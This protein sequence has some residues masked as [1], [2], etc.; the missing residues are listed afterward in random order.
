M[1]T[2]INNHLHQR[3]FLSFWTPVPT[4]SRI[5]VACC[6]RISN[7]IPTT[8]RELV[9]SSFW[10]PELHGRWEYSHETCNHIIAPLPVHHTKYILTPLP[11][12]HSPSEAK[13]STNLHTLAALQCPAT[14]TASLGMQLY[15][16]RYQEIP[17]AS[18]TL[19]RYICRSENNAGQWSTS[20]FLIGPRESSSNAWPASS[21]M[22]DF[23]K[24]DWKPQIPRQITW[25]P[26]HRTGNI[27]TGY[28]FQTQM[29]V[30]EAATLLV[31]FRKSVDVFS[32]K[33][34]T[35]GANFRH[36]ATRFPV[37]GRGE[38]VHEPGSAHGGD[39]DYIPVSHRVRVCRR[40]RGDIRGDRAETF[41]IDL[42]WQTRI[43]LPTAAPRRS[44]WI[45]QELQ[46]GRGRRGQ[47]WQPASRGP[48]WTAVIRISKATEKFK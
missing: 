16:K 29:V 33:R 17:A 38:E 12:P 1:F 28:R 14:T 10:F 20:F 25:K 42:K 11:R 31:S 3:R 9:Q 30:L 4:S 6:W 44:Q 45:Q 18:P 2:A 26:V 13:P 5:K 35:D 27:Y 24:C 32:R 19:S 41:F 7:T 46:Q 8:P 39:V 36:Y 22:S 47:R 34:K 40:V 37:A 23:L 15:N 43:R 21:G 48:S